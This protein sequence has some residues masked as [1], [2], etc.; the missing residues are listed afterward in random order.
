MSSHHAL[1]F[2]SCKRFVT[3][4]QCTHALVRTSA[5]CSDTETI[6]SLLGRRSATMAKSNSI[7]AKSQNFARL[8]R[9][10]KLNRYAIQPGRSDG[11][12]LIPQQLIDRRLRTRLLVDPLDDDRAIQRRSA[13]RTRH[14]AWYNDGVGWHAPVMHVSG[15]AIDDLG[16]CANVNAHGE[17][18]TF[19][20]DNAFRHFRACAD[21]AVILDDHGARL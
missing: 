19:A 21:K 5:A 2:R 16:R 14:A 4:A 12:C 18:G 1:L 17:H 15:G 20:D 3:T 6:S 10:L 9:P 7:G 8:I 13:A 11:N